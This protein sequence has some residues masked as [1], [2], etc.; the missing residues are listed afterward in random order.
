MAF[1][2]ALPKI[3]IMYRQF[4]RHPRRDH[5]QCTA[6]R[7]GAVRLFRPQSD[8]IACRLTPPILTKKGFIYNIHVFVR[9]EKTCAAESDRRSKD[10]TILTP[11]S[12]QHHTK[13]ATADMQHILFLLRK[14]MTAELTRSFHAMQGGLEEFLTI[15]IARPLRIQRIRHHRRRRLY[16]T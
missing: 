8:P 5:I 11:S 10:C 16:G 2:C 15:E 4:E 12:C 14:K 3:Q 9:V 13:M 1:C 7:C 6:W